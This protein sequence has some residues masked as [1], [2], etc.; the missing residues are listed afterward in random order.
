MID[1][2]NKNSEYDIKNI[3]YFMKTVGVDY[4]G[5]EILQKFMEQVLII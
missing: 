2:G 5:P 1:N 4:M 3:I